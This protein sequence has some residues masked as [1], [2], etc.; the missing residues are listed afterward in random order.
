MTDEPLLE[1]RSASE[2]DAASVAAVVVRAYANEQGWV[3]DAELV[4]GERTTPDQVRAMIRAPRSVV[5]VAVHDATIVATCHLR[6]SDRATAHLGML[7]VDPAWQSRG[8]SRRLR[9][10][11]IAFAEEAMACESVE[12]EVLSV[13]EGLRRVYERSGFIATGETRPFPAHV[14]RV[15]GLHFVVLRRS[16]GASGQNPDV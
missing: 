13:H 1:I 11:A 2:T 10:A 7:A 8:I 6:A 12:L 15:A 14:A 3:S 16:L 4:T 5:L 9:T